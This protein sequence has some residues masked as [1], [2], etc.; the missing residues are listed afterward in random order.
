MI[1]RSAR[2]CDLARPGRSRMLCRTW[3][4][5]LV[6]TVA[7]KETWISSRVFEG[8]EATV[9]IWIV[10]FAAWLGDSLCF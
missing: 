8:L 7:R 4:V 10:W 3:Y 1:K 2:A 9:Y 6:C 5:A